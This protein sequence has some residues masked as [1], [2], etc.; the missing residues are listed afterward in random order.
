[1]AVFEVGY[2]PNGEVESCISDSILTRG[3]IIRL[4]SED[5]NDGKKHIGLKAAVTD[6]DFGVVMNPA[7]AVGDAVD[8]FRGPGICPVLIGAGGIAIGDYVV[9]GTNGKG[10]ASAPAP[11]TIHYPAGRAE[12]AGADTELV[13][14]NINIGVQINNAVS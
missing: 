14:T 13:E 6:K 4:I 5:A 10:V 2:T 8:I 7:V 9:G 1:M 3:M 12:Q 11:G